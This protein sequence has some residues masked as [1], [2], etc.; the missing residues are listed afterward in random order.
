MPRFFFSFLSLFFLGCI[1]CC[2]FLKKK[3]K[4][5]TSGMVRRQE[6]V[7]LMLLRAQE[8]C[9]NLDVCRFRLGGSLEWIHDELEGSLYE[10]YFSLMEDVKGA[11]GY[12]QSGEVYVC[13]SWVEE[14]QSYSSLVLVLRFL[15]IDR[16]TTQPVQ[17]AHFLLS[18]SSSPTAWMESVVT[19]LIS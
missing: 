19:R 17:S 2:S 15:M 5:G 8:G 13:T 4:K 6:N 10:S 9:S 16:L 1:G 11:E 14:S 7:Y 3:K 12:H 18:A